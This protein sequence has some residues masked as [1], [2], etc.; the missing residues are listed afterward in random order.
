MV[1]YTS[2]LDF[3]YL[4]KVGYFEYLAFGGR[5]NGLYAHLARALKP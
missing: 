4:D 3:G 5:V 2:P 1:L